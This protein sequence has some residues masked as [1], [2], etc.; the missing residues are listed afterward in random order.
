MKRCIARSFVFTLFLFSLVT[1]SFTAQA[2][3]LWLGNNGTASQG[4][5]RVTTTGT[6][7]GTTPSL[8]ATGIASNGKFLFVSDSA[9]NISKVDLVT[10]AVIGSP[11]QVLCLSN[12][13]SDMAFDGQFLWRITRDGVLQK[14]NPNT[15]SLIQEVLL[16]VLDPFEFNLLIGVGLTW[17]GTRLIG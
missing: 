14:I 5:L 17:D 7:L 16:D 2:Q 10:G 4:L 6:T 9:G 3:S 15:L 11:T 8:A 1:L 13:C 12:L